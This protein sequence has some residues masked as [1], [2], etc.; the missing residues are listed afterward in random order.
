MVTFDEKFRC[1]NIE[2]FVSQ[3]Q[4]QNMFPLSQLLLGLKSNRDTSINN[5][6]VGASSHHDS[7]YILGLRIQRDPSRYSDGAVP[8]IPNKRR[9]HKVHRFITIDRKGVMSLLSLPPPC[10]MERGLLQ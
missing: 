5:G 8:N 3:I 6:T 4:T 2:L 7:V 1:I 10:Y 9:I